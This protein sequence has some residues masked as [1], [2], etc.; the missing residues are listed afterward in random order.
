[1]GGRPVPTGHSTNVNAYNPRDIRMAKLND[2]SVV[3]YHF[4]SPTLTDYSGG[5]KDFASIKY[6]GPGRIL[7]I[8]EKRYTPG[9]QP[10]ELH[11]WTLKVVIIEV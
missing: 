3:D 5:D 4:C 9:E 7:Q 8:K 6:L 2:G 1:M 11:F 10:E